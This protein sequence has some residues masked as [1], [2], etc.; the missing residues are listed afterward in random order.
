MIHTERDYRQVTD[1][2]R[3]NVNK[4]GL[5][6]KASPRK[7]LR[8]NKEE[9]EAL[10]GRGNRLFTPKPNLQGTT[11]KPCEHLGV[12][13]SVSTDWATPHTS[14]DTS[15]A[16]MPAAGLLI[17]QELRFPLTHTKYL[18]KLHRRRRVWPVIINILKVSSVAL[19]RWSF[20][21]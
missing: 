3:D 6:I 18:L 5:G 8:K 19:I 12:I 20:P 13:T 4:W 11:I 17:R 7:G 9:V 1:Q 15:P 16:P 10:K 21:L 2:E 14:N